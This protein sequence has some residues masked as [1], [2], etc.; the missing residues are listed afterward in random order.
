[1]QSVFLRV[2]A[3]AWAGLSLLLALHWFVDLGMVGFPDGYITPFARATGPLLHLLA[4][5]CL[6]QGLYF[7]YR[8]LFGKGFGVLGLGLQILIA[9]ILTVAPAL[10]VRNCPHSQT[11][12]NAYEALTNTMMDDGIGG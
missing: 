9:A 5:A 10:I 12:S 3:L 2:A 8:T 1:M 7:L 11:C 4:A 6:I